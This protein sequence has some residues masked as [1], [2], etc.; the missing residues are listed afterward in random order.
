[1]VNKPCILKFFFILKHDLQ[2]LE[3]LLKVT[4]FTLA[5][6]SAE[7]FTCN[8]VH[9]CVYD[10]YRQILYQVHVPVIHV[11]EERIKSDSHF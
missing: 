3:L 11:Q 2:L 10:H 5:S 4:L 9:V 7:N 8:M 6:S 1:M